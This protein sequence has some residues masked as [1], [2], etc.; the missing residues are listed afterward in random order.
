MSRSKGQGHNH[1]QERADTFTELKLC[2]IEYVGKAGCHVSPSI[3]GIRPRHLTC[4]LSSASTS[5]RRTITAARRDGLWIHRPARGG[6]YRPHRSLM[7]PQ[8][9]SNMVESSHSLNAVA[10]P[11]FVCLSVCLSSA[12][13]V[14]STQ[15]V[16]ILGSVST[17]FGTLTIR[18]H[19]RKI[20]RRSSHGNTSVGGGLNARGV[21]KYS[22]FGPTSSLL[23]CIQVLTWSSTVVPCWWTLPVSGSQP[24]TSPSFNAIFITG[25]PPYASVNHRSRDRDEWRDCRLKS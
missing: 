10:R 25:R 17:P 12:A 15:P 21:A 14:H 24:T 8:S 3:F 5:I 19:P 6:G 7:D 11:S 4:A 20:L 1:V 2:R 16:E 13:F 22:N 23:T 9:A 18:W